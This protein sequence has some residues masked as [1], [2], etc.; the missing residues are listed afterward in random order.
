MMKKAI[1]VA[2]FGTTHLD[3]LENNIA[4]VEKDIQSRYPQLPVYRAFTS[5]IVRRR[6]KERYGMAVDSPE[7]ALRRLEREGFTHI[8]VQPTLL[9]GGEEYEKLRG[10]LLNAAGGMRVT[11]G[12]PLLWDEGDI[13]AMAGT[14][15][16]AYPLPED[17]IL[18]AMGH[19]TAHAA[20]ATYDRLRRAMNE[21]GM[22][23]C[24]VEG[25]LDFDFAVQA[26]LAQPRRKVHLVPLLLVAGDHSVNDMAGDEEDSLKRRLEAAG[27][28]ASY[29]L[30]GL[31]EIPAVRE[32]IC[33]RVPAER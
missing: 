1:L 6:L 15:K 4:A 21:Q 18:L 11:V 25:S 2:S 12:R 20:D 31:G 5:T 22:E 9:L 26:L 19:G 13:Q 8:A 27:F 3:T 30:R 24:T 17:T 7:E 29:S 14:L 16:A 32:M 23:L 28:T 33:R 10:T